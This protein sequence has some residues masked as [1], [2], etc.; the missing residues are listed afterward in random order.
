MSSTC[1]NSYA[2]AH[3]LKLTHP[4]LDQE[5]GVLRS[6]PKQLLQP[7][8][9]LREFVVDLTYVHCLQKRIVVRVTRLADVHKQVLVVLHKELEIRSLQ[10]IH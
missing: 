8:L 7:T 4:E 10:H 6:F 1:A 5:E 2:A 3:P 9:L